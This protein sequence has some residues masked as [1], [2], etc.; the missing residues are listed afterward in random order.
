M[1]KHK[2]TMKCIFCKRNFTKTSFLKHTQKCPEPMDGDLPLEPAYLLQVE[3]R[4]R[5][6]YCLI[7][8]APAGSTLAE[9]D[10][11]LRD[12]WLECCGHLS[13]FYIDRV[14][15]TNDP[16]SPEDSEMDHALGDL[17]EENQVFHYVYDFGSSTQ[18]VIKVAAQTDAP[19]GRGVDI[20]ARNLPPEYKCDEC[21]KTAAHISLSEEQLLCE[22][23]FDD[24]EDSLPIV[25]SPRVGVCCYTG[26]EDI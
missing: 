13:S 19:A 3:G 23:C 11:I 26:E 2:V 8:S 17:L 10:E 4:Y 5:K 14:E 25:N 21:G 12:T 7:L 18:L 22:D 9:L 20:L 1:P 16:D 15:Y 6:Q 24:I